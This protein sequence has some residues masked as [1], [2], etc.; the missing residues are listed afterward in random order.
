MDISTIWYTVQDLYQTLSQVRRP[1]KLYQINNFF[2]MVDSDMLRELLRIGPN[3]SSETEAN[4]EQLDLLEKFKKS[5]TV[6]AASFSLP[7]GYV[8]HVD[9]G[10]YTSGGVPVDYVSIREYTDRKDNSL[11]APSTTYP[12]FYISEGNIITDPVSVATATYTFW[13][14]GENTGVNKPLLALKSEDG[15]TKYDSGN[16]VQFVWPEYM[17]STIVFKVLE[18]LGVSVQDREM[19]QKKLIENS[20]VA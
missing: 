1:L 15:I 12:I 4:N 5:T 11:T 7:A 3:P 17:Y 16:S 10:T 2:Q 20:H 19:I 14:Y 13:Y 9:G 18:Y 8:R 6:N